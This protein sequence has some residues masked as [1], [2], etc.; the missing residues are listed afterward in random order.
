M[1]NLFQLP[2]APPPPSLRIKTL[3]ERT[4]PLHIRKAV[5]D[6]RVIGGFYEIT[7]TLTFYN[8]YDRRLEGMLEIPL[9]LKATVC[10]FAVETNGVLVHACAVEKH[11]ARK[12]FENEVRKG[13]TDAVAIVEQTSG[14]I[15]RTRIWPLEPNGTKTV[16][17]TYS[18]QLSL[19]GGQGS[20]QDPLASS[21][22][23]QS[24]L[25]R[26][27]DH[28]FRRLL[29][30]VPIDT[31]GSISAC[32]AVFWSLICKGSLFLPVVI[33]GCDELV[34]S[35]TCAAQPL[36]RLPCGTALN[37]CTRSNS[38]TLQRKVVRPQRRLL[39]AMAVP[40]LITGQPQVID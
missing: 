32:C 4:E 40:S 18:Q 1:S 8:K 28:L 33:T 35:A 10:G 3:G 2:H 37:V 14:N 34:M 16:M 24:P 23:T 15:Y 27:G 25:R 36:A 29:A 13:G 17:L 5:I 38:S 21:S 39:M 26:L 19:S 30:F 7:Q 11:Q 31:L 22:L 9:P 20:I 12:V 6:V